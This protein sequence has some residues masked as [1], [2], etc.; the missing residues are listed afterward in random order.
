[1]ARTDGYPPQTINS[2]IQFLVLKEYAVRDYSI[3]SK[4]MA[5]CNLPVL[6]KTEANGVKLENQDQSF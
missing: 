6:L 5:F 1:M 3:G 2:K 4:D